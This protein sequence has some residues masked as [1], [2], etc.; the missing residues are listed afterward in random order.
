MRPDD[1]GD[2]LA[3]LRDRGL[4][5]EL[6]EANWHAGTEDDL[7]QLERAS[8]EDLDELSRLWAERQELQ[9]QVGGSEPVEPATGEWVPST[10]VCPVCKAAGR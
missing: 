4:S 8:D 10:F 3:A 7:Q 5:A 6:A 1:W 2:R 9:E